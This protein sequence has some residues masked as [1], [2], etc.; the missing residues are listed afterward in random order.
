MK[1]DQELYDEMRADYLLGF[2]HYSKLHAVG[3]DV[4]TKCKYC[5]ISVWIDDGEC[6]G[7]GALIEVKHEK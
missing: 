6:P 2:V 3:K 5:R 1:I 7:C 4:I